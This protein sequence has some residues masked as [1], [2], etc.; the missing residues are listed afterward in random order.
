MNGNMSMMTMA[1]MT[2]LIF[3]IVLYNM[4]KWQSNKF[5]TYAV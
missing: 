3:F 2:S 5:R 4:F 1:A